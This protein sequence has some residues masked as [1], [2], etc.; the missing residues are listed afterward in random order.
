MSNNYYTHGSFP[1]TGSAATSASMRAELDLVTAGFDK[2]PTLTGNGNKFVVIN[3]LG[4]AMTVT[5]TLPAASVLDNQFTVLDNA[6]NTKAFQF[7]A[8]GISTATTR[9]F[10]MPDAN[11]TLVGIDVAQ[12]LT[13]KTISGLSNTLTNIANGSLVNSAVT[14]N[15]VSVSLGASGTITAVNP[16]AL[17]IG[18]GLSGSSYSG[19][20]G[21]TIAID[22]TVA[23]LTGSQTLTNKTLTSPVISTIS[24]TG[25]LTLPTSTDTLVGRAT[26]DTLTNKTLST[27]S[28][29]NGNVVAT[30]Y[31]GTG[32]S[33][34][35]AGDLTYYASGTA[36]S[37]L[38][39]GTSGQV[40][41]STGSAP[42]WTTLTG[43]AVTSLS[44]GTTGLTPS[45]GTNGAITVA[46]TL[47]VASG[48]T[49]GTT[50]A[51]A[52]T[53]LQ[54]DPA[55]TATAMAIALG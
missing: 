39:I 4:T 30:T 51:A 16:N 2:L 32:L 21:V 20:A 28:T 22:S 7:D 3:A 1:S 18:T 49:G 26:T 54:V 33:T 12:T 11:T 35:T 43:I 24:N 27:G 10:T 48:G 38:A 19:A 44:F 15:G 50:V 23:T 45:T 14:F 25:T 37:K 42:Q 36:L 52:Q 55:G 8:A 29:W 17:T 41:T 47:A 40:L 9:T 53:N 13:N 34:F 46:G 6:D 5:S 31:G